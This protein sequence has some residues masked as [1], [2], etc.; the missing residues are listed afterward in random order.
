M[1][2]RE[3]PTASQPWWNKRYLISL[4]RIAGLGGPVSVSP[5]KAHA[6]RGATAMR[7]AR[8]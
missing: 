3:Q 7:L 4:G 8:G 6:D 2:S 1:I 5:S